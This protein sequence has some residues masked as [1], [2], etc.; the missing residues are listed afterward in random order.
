METMTFMPLSAR[1]RARSE[2]SREPLVNSVTSAD[3]PDSLIKRE[4]WV[5]AGQL[6]EGSPP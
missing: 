6:R 3:D 4:V 2:V 5:I 1:N